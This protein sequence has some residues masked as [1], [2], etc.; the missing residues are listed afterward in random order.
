MDIRVFKF[1][2]ASVNGAAGVR[3]VASILKSQSPGKFVVVI[4]AMGKT[5][6]SM[7]EMLGFYMENDVVP[8]VESFNR[9]YKYHIGI[10]HELFPEKEHPVYRELDSLF[11]KLRGHIRRS[12]LTKGFI[13]KY[14]FEYDQIV[15]YGELFSSTLLHHYLK[16]AGISNRLFDA[17][18][19]IRTDTGYRDAKID[20]TGT[21]QQI[22]AKL[23]RYFSSVRKERQIG[24]TQ[25]FIGRD[26]QGNT[27][28]LGRE[29]SDFSAAIFAFSLGC[30]ELTIWKDVPGIMNAD[31]KWMRDAKKLDTLSYLEAIELAYYGAS[32]IHPKTI[33]PLEN[34]DIV[35]HVKS[36]MR[37]KEKGTVVRNMKKWNV[38]FP[39]FIRKTDQVLISLSP[40]DF[41]FIMEENLSQIFSILAKYRTKVNVMQNSAI[42]FSICID[43][44]P[45]AVP[46]LLKELKNDYIIRYND[47]LELVTIRHYDQKSIH[48]ISLNHHILLE[49]KTRNTVHL[50]KEYSP[51]R[52]SLPG[53]HI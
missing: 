9:I 8:M 7:Q 33:K 1:G 45:Q 41:S 26:P 19:L 35:L 18:D 32:V 36:F 12:H 16:S 14:D 29:G 39:I 2:G 24:L 43:A 6:N 50:V 11:E 13:L 42:S 3:N 23:G 53:N 17:R 44:N 46:L 15:S 31:P 38:P 47:K 30:K 22:R 25:G 21:R 49:Q 51:N 37:P 48:R 34:A 40:R 20:W 5:T 28:T 52:E 27:T 10:A 4:S